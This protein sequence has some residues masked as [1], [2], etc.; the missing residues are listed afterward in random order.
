L[1]LDQTLERT[2]RAGGI[3]ASGALTDAGLLRLLLLFIA[4]PA[5]GLFFF[6]GFPGDAIV[7]IV[8]ALAIGAMV[9][10]LARSVDLS[11]TARLD[12][13]SFCLALSVALCL[14]G[15]EGRFFYANDDWLIRDAIVN[16][17]VLQHWPFVYQIDGQ[18]FVMRAP[19]AMYMFPAAVGKLYG[20][21]AAHLALL[22][23]NAILFALIFYFIVPPRLKSSQAALVIFIFVIFG[24]LDILPTLGGYL[25]TGDF[26]NDH[27]ERWAGLFE[28]SSHITQLFWVPHHAFAG[29]AFACLYLLWRRGCVHISVVVCATLY[30]AYWSPF[31]VIGA[32]PFLL[33]ALISD[34]R[35]E[36]VGR[37]DLIPVVLGAGP[38]ALLWIYLIRGGSSVVHS[39][40]FGE[41]NFWP[42]YFDFIYV[43]FVP[44]AAVLVALRPALIR[45]ASF[46]IVVASLL[47]VPFYKLGESNDFAMRASIPALALL[48]AT[49]A[50]AL[51]EEFEAGNRPLWA[52]LATIILMVGSITGAMEI[53]RALVRPPSPVGT[54]NFVQAW[55]QSSFN[56]IPMT[57]YLINIDAMPGWM[58]P[59]SPAVVAAGAP[60]QCFAQ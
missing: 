15:G 14:L 24:G 1:A 3:A 31:A 38:A 46:W 11:A 39:F 49:L 27:I 45:D 59:Q 57:S 30:L 53:R 16:D 18:N 25:R 17:L 52:R 44:Y 51:T 48:A 56:W 9:F 21:Y 22:A 34:W 41:P 29:W 19:L 60:T 58:R 33:Y 10:Y 40:M 28:Y 32:A 6:L 47:L 37:A 35:V 20:L 54:C 7:G 42:I 13:L 50:T 26:G 5:A 36:K 2:G 23:Q 55:S 4:A 8:A 43:E 12:V